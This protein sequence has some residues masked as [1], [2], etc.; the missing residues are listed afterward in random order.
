MIFVGILLF[1]QA[2]FAFYSDILARFIF[3]SLIT[4]L[5]LVSLKVKLTSKHFFKYLQYL[6]NFRH[7]VSVS[8]SLL[9][10]CI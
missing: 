3:L 9:S 10:M 8:P 4:S 6:G 7:S 2:L 1:W 5:E